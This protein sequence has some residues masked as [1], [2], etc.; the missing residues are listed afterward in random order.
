[1]PIATHS[2]G[3]LTA[4]KAPLVQAHRQVEEDGKTMIRIAADV[5]VQG[6]EKRR[7]QE[8][9][10]VVDLATARRPKR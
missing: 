5:A 1:M 4:T 10:E 9:C 3:T 7:A 6:D 8:R 2:L